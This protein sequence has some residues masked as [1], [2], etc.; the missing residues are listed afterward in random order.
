VRFLRLIGSRYSRFKKIRIGYTLLKS[1]VKSVL[2][3]HQHF[4]LLS[5]I[6]A[7][8]QLIH[9]KVTGLIHRRLTL[10]VL[11][12]ELLGGKNFFE[13]LWHEASFI[14]SSNNFFTL[15]TYIVLIYIEIILIFFVLCSAAHYTHMEHDNSILKSMQKSVRH[16]RVI[17]EWAFIELCAQGFSSLLAE[18]GALL[19][20]TWNIITIFDVQI[21]S[22]DDVSPYGVLKKSLRLFKQSFSE[23]VALDVIIEGLLITIGLAIY[24]V[25]E[26]YLGSAS[27]DPTWLDYNSMLIFLILYLMSSVIIFEVVLFTKLYKTIEKN[28]KSLA[29]IN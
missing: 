14:P 24:T 4:L 5:I 16:W 11:M 18:V 23:V 15:F 13:I 28:Q 21:L 2:F 20:F 22:F 26:E 25:S 3:S 29:S 7:T 27:I 12:T 8:I 17:C 6:L 9:F 19:Y 10:S 1:S